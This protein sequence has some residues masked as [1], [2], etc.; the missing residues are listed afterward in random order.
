MT[1]EDIKKL[2]DRE[3]DALLAEKVLGIDLS[4]R[5]EHEWRK[6]EDGEVDEWA[7]EADNLLIC[8]G[9]RC[10]RCGYSYCVNCDE[11]NPR[12]SCKPEPICYSKRLDA[13]A[14]LEAKTREEFMDANGNDIYRQTLSILLGNSCSS[15]AAV[16]F[17]DPYL[18][19]AR[20]RAEACLLCWEGE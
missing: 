6:D 4:S 2:S 9:P 17:P 14:P 15:D 16:A 12:P 7:Y 1:L 20:H 19:S 3:L 10:V 8:H 5:P 13:I 11:D 18:A